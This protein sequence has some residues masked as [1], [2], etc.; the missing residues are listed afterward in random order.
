MKDVFVINSYPEGMET[1]WCDVD[2]Y[3]ELV[4]VVGE[5]TWQVMQAKKKLVLEW[6]LAPAKQK[7]VPFFGRE[8]TTT[9]PS[10]LENSADHIRMMNEDGA[11]AAKMV[12]KDGDPEAG[13][14]KAK[15]IIERTYTA[16][17]LA[18]NCMEPMNF[19]A[20]VTADKAELVGP[21]Q[22]PEF[23]EKTVA[24]RL[25]MTL[26]QI[27]L[28]MTRMGGGCLLQSRSGCRR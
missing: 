9:T 25:G 27:D 10:G 19:F 13:F 17:F 14:A 8:L 15:T 6:E 20:N 16:P 28:Q 1:Q 12:R 2:A 3:P 11:A 4:A 23:M 18:H 24:A 26:E 21:V 7:T 22:T 5:S